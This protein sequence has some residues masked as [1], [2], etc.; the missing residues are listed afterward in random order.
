MAAR[1]DLLGPALHHRLRGGHRALDRRVGRCGRQG[2]PRSTSIVVRTATGRC[3]ARAD[4]GRGDRVGARARAPQR[5]PGGP[6]AGERRPAAGRLAAAPGRVAS[7]VN[8]PKEQTLV[9]PAGS[10]RKGIRDRRRAGR[11][12]GQ[13]RPWS[14][15]RPSPGGGPPAP[16]AGDH[17]HRAGAQ[18]GVDPVLR[19]RGAQGQD[20]RERGG[21][22]TCTCAARPRRRR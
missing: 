13:D 3:R 1:R 2:S 10:G 14:R 21:A 16:Q 20:R 11:W 4:G 19:P 18:G 9:E 7:R 17:R 6:P 12:S 5:P 15:R 8:R 22:A